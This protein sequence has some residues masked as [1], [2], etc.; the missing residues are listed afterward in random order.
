V[1]ILKK[2]KRIIIL[3]KITPITSPQSIIYALALY[4]V[5]VDIRV[6]G[7]SWKTGRKLFR[8]VHDKDQMF[9]RES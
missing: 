2:I 9:A 6:L 3:F 1:I 4:V 8:S 5:R 7:C